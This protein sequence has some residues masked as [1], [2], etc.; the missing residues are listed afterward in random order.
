MQARLVAACLAA[1]T[2]AARA[3]GHRAARDGVQFENVARRRASTSR[4]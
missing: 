1:L 3:T 4:T 2:S